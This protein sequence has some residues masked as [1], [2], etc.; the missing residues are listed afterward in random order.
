MK[1]E[2]YKLN[3]FFLVGPTAAGKTAVSQWIAENYQFDILSADSMM[4][5][6]GLDIG[7]AKP[8][9]TCRAKVQYWGLDLVSAYEHFS[10]GKFREYAIN[11]VR[12]ISADNR[13]VIVAGGTGLYIKSL[14]HGL[15][16]SPFMDYAFRVKASE[17]MEK[18]GIGALQRLVK[19]QAPEVYES[20]ADKMNP[21]RL[22]RAV[23]TA[24]CATDKNQWKTIGK[25]PAIAGLMLP[26]K[27][28]H[29]RI[30][31]RV[32]EMYSGG[33]LDEVGLLL[34]QG[35]EKTPTAG[36]AIG[37]AEAIDYLRGKISLADA[38]ELTVKRTRQ[39]AKRQMT[40]FKHQANV[41]WQMIDPGMTN[42]QIGKMVMDCWQKTGPTPIAE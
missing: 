29:E 8:D 30:E 26:M 19:I 38:I 22:I 36:K 33:L 28:L 14:T 15:T 2:A 37:Y 1:R 18:G 32:R 31:K 9:K 39:L 25:G 27:Q 5:Y 35:F 23:E 17:I 12:K 13:R 24:Y 40:W 20:I 7:T 42:K 41:E 6:R 34:K 4:V 16:R 11:A 3:A 10:A 21:R